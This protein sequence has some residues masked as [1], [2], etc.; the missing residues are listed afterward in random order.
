[1]NLTAAGLLEASGGGGGLTG[2]DV[3]EVMA[4]GGI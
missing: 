2:V 4:R 1:M 3:R